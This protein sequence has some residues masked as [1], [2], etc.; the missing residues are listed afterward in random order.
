M[1]ITKFNY[2]VHLDNKDAIFYYLG[3]AMNNFDAECM[4]WKEFT[5]HLKLAYQAASE[6]GEE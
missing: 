3:D 1:K 6:L 4:T 5:E 2:M